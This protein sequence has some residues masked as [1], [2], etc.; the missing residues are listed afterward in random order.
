[1]CTSWVNMGD[2]VLEGWIA[3][4]SMDYLG[5]ITGLFFHTTDGGIT[6]T[7]HQTLDNCFPMDMDFASSKF[8]VVSC[9]TSSGLTS[10]I[11]VYQ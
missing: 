2:N 1:M 8:G 10:M 6:Y 4:A 5:R 11:A 3:G 9:V 7:L